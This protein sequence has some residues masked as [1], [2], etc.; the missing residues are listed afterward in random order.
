MPS[1]L[2]KAEE[3][4][5]GS[6]VLNKVVD[7]LLEHGADFERPGR[8]GKDAPPPRRLWIEATCRCAA[9]YSREARR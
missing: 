9:F 5:K 6:E 8:R 1:R 2:Q 3:M 7:T 4:E